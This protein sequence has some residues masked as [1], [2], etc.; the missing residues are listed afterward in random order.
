MFKRIVLVVTVSIMAALLVACAGHSS[1]MV[2][3]A[4]KYSIS[5]P[6]EWGDMDTE[7]GG[8]MLGAMT[9][10][11]T[12]KP[13]DDSMVGF[14]DISDKNVKAADITTKLRPRANGETEEIE[15]GGIGGIKTWW[16]QGTD[17]VMVAYLA[18]GEK[19]GG[20]VVAQAPVS[21]EKTLSQLD[22]VVS[23]LSY[24]SE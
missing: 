15:S 13:T 8:M 7:S 14:A 6:S 24:K 19:I 10:L 4:G 3:H 12:V 22:E 16:D 9:S 17:R 1:T 2:A 11:Y 23:S 5:Y 21:D 18:E 20:V